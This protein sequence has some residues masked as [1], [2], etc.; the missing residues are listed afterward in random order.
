MVIGLEV[1]DPRLKY[2]I[3]RYNNWPISQGTFL[4]FPPK[5]ATVHEA[6]INASEQAFTVQPSP[7]LSA[8]TLWS[9]QTRLGL[10]KPRFR[11]RDL[12]ERRAKVWL[13]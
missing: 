10:S 5:N 4:S 2:V 1:H 9:E 7:L 8:S 3:Y 11:K 12:D 13:S 6:E